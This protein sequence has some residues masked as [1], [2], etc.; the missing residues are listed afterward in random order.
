MSVLRGFA[1]VS[2]DSRRGYGTAHGM[3]GT[4]G[5]S[6][7]E[8]RPSGPMLDSQNIPAGQ[9]RRALQLRKIQ[10][11]LLSV[12]ARPRAPITIGSSGQSM[13]WPKSMKDPHTPCAGSIGLTVKQTPRHGLGWP[14]AGGV[15]GIPSARAFGSEPIM[16]QAPVRTLHRSPALQ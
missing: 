3:F 2:G 4:I 11:P 8:Q 12:P 7:G 13:V 16:P 5:S 14:I 6:T 1:V 15:Q 10:R 9:Q